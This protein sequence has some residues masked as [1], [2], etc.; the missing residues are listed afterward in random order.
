MEKEIEN[1]DKELVGP[2]GG[3]YTIHESSEV[4]L[5]HEHEG[6]D[7]IASNSKGHNTPYPLRPH[8]GLREGLLAGPNQSFFKILVL[9]W[10]KDDKYAWYYFG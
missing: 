2:G 4:V 6:L 9:L 8:Y 1:L 5:T 7:V 10:L 3:F